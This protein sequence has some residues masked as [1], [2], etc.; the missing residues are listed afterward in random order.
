MKKH[1]VAHLGLGGRGTVHANAFL[2]L[3]DRYDLAGLCELREERLKEYC[4]EKRLS[5]SLCYTSC[6]KMLAETRPEVL[7]FITQPD[8]RLS[9]VKLAAKY[10]VKA[11]ALEKPMAT[12]LKEAAEI[13]EICGQHR[14]KGVVSHQQKYLTSFQ[15]LKEIVESG[16]IG[17]IYLIT[18]SCQAWLSQLGTHFVDYTLWINN[19]K[20]A[21]WVV[22]H[23]HGKELLSDHHPSPNYVMG[24]IGFENGVR[25]FVE[26]GK[27]SASHMDKSMFWVDNRLTVYGSNGNAWAETN[28]RWGALL[29]GRILEEQGEDWGTQE[30]RRLQ[31][32]YFRDFAD[33]LDGTILD[34]PCNLEYAYHGYEIMEALCISAMNHIR[35]D[36]PLDTGNMQDIFARMREEL[37]ECP[38]R[39]SQ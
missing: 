34:H 4:A 14:I 22:G 32:L 11:I 27:L 23:V 26:F 38:E 3:E 31:P 35:V 8:V 20:K 6:E 37:P 24:Q 29:N 10:G 5:P 18:A 39:T 17:K 25:A 2:E 13:H 12:S 7:C 33:W 16:R 1:R 36:L 9:M 15:K 30:C 21:D 28:G 19:F